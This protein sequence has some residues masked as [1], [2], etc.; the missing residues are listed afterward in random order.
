MH[1][2]SRV[3]ANKLIVKLPLGPRNGPKEAAN[4]GLSELRFRGRKLPRQAGIREADPVMA[5][6]AKRLVRRLA[7]AAQGDDSP[8]RQPERLAVCIMNFKFPLEAQ[9]TVIEGGNFSCHRVDGS[10]RVR[11]S[12]ARGPG[13]WGR[14]K[15]GIGVWARDWGKGARFARSC[16]PKWVRSGLGGGRGSTARG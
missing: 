10:T 12:G 6:I 14:G 8:A 15:S 9:W 2:H 4:Q 3:S 16:F 13:A 11:A 5:A 7:A 1:N